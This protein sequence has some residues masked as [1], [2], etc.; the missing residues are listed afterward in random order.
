[1]PKPYTISFI[2]AGYVGLPW[3][4]TFASLGHT[5]YLVDVDKNKIKQIKAGVCPIVEEGLPKL[6]KKVLKSGHL[7]PTTDYAKAI[8]YSTV[9]FICVGT[10]ESKSGH[11]NLSY[12]YSATEEIAANLGPQ[13][14]VIVNRS[15]VSPGT[16][17]AVAKII[18]KTVSRSRFAVVSSP[19]FLR[20]GHAL[21]DTKDPSRF[22]IGS[23]NK[24]AIQIMKR[25]YKSWSS[26]ILVMNESSSELVK[27]ASNAYLAARIVFADQIANLAESV[28]GDVQ[29]VLT[30]VGLDD[31]IGDHF[32]YPGLG[33]GG[34]CFPKDV[35]ALGAVYQQNHHFEP[36]LFSYLNA[37][38]SARI[39]RVTNSLKHSL[40]ELKGKKIAVWGLSAKPQSPDMRG[41][42]PV[43]LIKELV[44]QG[45]KVSVFDPYVGADAKKYVPKTVVVCKDYLEA[46]KNVNILII[47][48]EHKIFKSYDLK[49][50]NKLM[51]GN[52]FYDAKRMFDPQA[53]KKLGFAYLGTGLG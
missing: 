46:V 34:Y 22:L 38:N 31:R 13:F 14:T 24:K 36:N 3:A 50:V 44:K 35:K 45:A 53:V 27:Y 5:T 16:A 21:E 52:L 20:Q 40:G 6:L 11:A 7:L 42:T 29:D 8:P 47:P 4:V 48:T 30:G 2:G 51:R 32:W 25:L 39:K 26:P 23:T 49:K 15:T 28:G 9:V 37:L 10:P 43:D 17:T 33:Y 12:V 19:E 1:M 41:S 18:E